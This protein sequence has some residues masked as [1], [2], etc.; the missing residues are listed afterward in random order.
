MHKHRMRRAAVGWVFGWLAAFSG[1]AQAAERAPATQ[2]AAQP[3][4]QGLGLG[5]PASDLAAKFSVTAIGAAGARSWYFFRNAQRIAVLKGDIDEVWH[6]D[7]QGRISFERVFHTERQA[8]DYST[9]ELATL[10][11]QSDW[12]AL[13]TLLDPREL[14]SLKLVS[15]TGQGAAQTLRLE[16]RRG[17]EFVRVDWLPA[18]QLPAR[19][20]RQNKAGRT[21]I[22]LLQHATT[23]PSAWPQPGQRS[24]DYLHFDAA[25]FGDMDYQPVV[26]KSEAMDIRAGWRVA[27]K[28]D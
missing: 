17:A 1:L 21:R 12:A 14:A 6:R 22:E 7:P 27:H 2:A 11:V 4:P 20:D 10:G 24:A 18:L 16:R 19:I 13:A 28:H 5:A 3:K 8:V 23:A 9:G 15:R 26:R 25:D